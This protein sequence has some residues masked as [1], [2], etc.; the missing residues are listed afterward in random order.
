MAK[1]GYLLARLVEDLLDLSRVTAGQFEI[2]RA[3]TLLNAVVQSSLEA[4]GPMAAGKGVA[5]AA[6]LDPEIEPID[7]DAQRLQQI[8]WN[9]LS[10]A[11]KFTAAG[12]RIVART[13]WTSD[14]AVLIISDTGVGFDQA[15]ASD[16]QASVRRIHR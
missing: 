9:L 3:P 14:A 4:L 12:G 5:L 15:F 11:V 16:V 7:A 8:A 13:R 6:E 10:N 2:A 1:N